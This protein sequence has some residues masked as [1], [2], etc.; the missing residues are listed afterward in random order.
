MVDAVFYF[1]PAMLAAVSEDHLVAAY[2]ADRAI[3]VPNLPA[4]EVWRKLSDPAYDGFEA[5]G[6]E[7]HSAY[8]TIAVR[9]R[10]TRSRPL[11]VEYF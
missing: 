7:T 11:G 2:C 5:Y 10:S 8:A 3:R 4:E 9:R 6:F 1:Q